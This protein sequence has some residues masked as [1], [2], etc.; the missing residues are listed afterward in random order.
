[1]YL[2]WIYI[3]FV[4]ILSGFKIGQLK[5]SFIKILRFWA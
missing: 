5:I 4:Q 2:I 3:E 1:M